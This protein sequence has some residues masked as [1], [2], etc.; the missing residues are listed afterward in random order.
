[1]IDQKKHMIQSEALSL[2]TLKRILTE[3]KR[4]S[5]PQTWKEEQRDE[6]LALKLIA[7]M[8][9]EYKKRM[10]LRGAFA[11]TKQSPRQYGD[12]FV[13]LRPPGNDMKVEP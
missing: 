3:A 7:K 11:A 9:K 2:L 12:C 13:G 6:E 5:P 4:E 1:M 10:S 8:K